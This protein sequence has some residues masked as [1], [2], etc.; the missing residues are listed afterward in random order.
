MVVCGNW[1]LRSELVDDNGH[2]WVRLDT[3]HDSFWKNLDTHTPSGIR[4]GRGSCGGASDSVPRR[5]MVGYVGLGAWFDSGYMVCVS[6]L[7]LFGWLFRIH[8]VMVFSDPEVDAALSMLQLLPLPV[9]LG[10]WTLR[11]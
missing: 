1:T 8:F 11:P 5:G 7:V 6:S 3:V 9:T 10:N 4:P 2:A